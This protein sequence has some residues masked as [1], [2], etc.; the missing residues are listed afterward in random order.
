MSLDLYFASGSQASRFKAVDH[1]R[2][3]RFQFLYGGC[4]EIVVQVARSRN[5]VSSPVLPLNDAMDAMSGFYLL[6]ESA[7]V[8]V[9]RVG[10][11]LDFKG[12][13]SW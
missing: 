11:A 5:D 12:S 8:C 4:A 2:D 7:D 6:T 1:P 3:Q 9:L 13:L 10:T